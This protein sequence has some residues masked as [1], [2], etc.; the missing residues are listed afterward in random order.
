MTE[1]KRVTILDVSRATGLA[2]STV[3]NALAGKNHVSEETRAT[4]LEA[5]T[6]LGYRASTV[7]RALRMQRSFTIGVLVADVANPSSPDFVRGVE[8]VA[9]REKCTL[10]L[11]NTDGDEERQLLHMR[12]L[13]DRQVDGMVLISQHVS[14]PAVRALLDASTPFVLI[15][16]RNPLFPDDYVGSDNVIGVSEAINHLHA[17][18]H[19]RIGFVR[20]PS[21]SSTAGERLE[22]FLA[23]A[24]R[25]R[26]KVDDELVFK[27]DYGFETGVAAGRHFLRLRRPPTAIMGSSDINALGVMEA[28]LESG[29][30]IPGQLSVVGLDDIAL[31]S[32]RAINLTTIHLQKR[33]MGAAAAD[34]L[35]ERIRQPD[36]TPQELIFPTRLVVRGSTAAPALPEA[37]RLRA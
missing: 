33:A 30:S 36:R 14:S 20:G 18:K 28:A 34:L 26:L 15:Q 3:S 32:F 22:T 21:D 9:I 6:R 7:A 24:K 23:E 35:I 29:L 31:A 5:A 2:L 11:S 12:T 17:L 13:L 25:L 37:P 19:R 4:V 10:L 16:R 1:R 8:D 27:G